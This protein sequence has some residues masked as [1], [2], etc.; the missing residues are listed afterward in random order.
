MSATTLRNRIDRVAD[1]L[2]AHDPADCPGEVTLI[3][4]DGEPIPDDAGRCRLC[5]SAHVLVIDENIIKHSRGD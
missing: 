5:G 4:D 2:T 3:L 1:R